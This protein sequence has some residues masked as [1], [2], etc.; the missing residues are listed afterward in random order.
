MTAPNR[1]R[2]DPLWLLLVPVATYIL[3]YAWLAAYHRRAQ[4]LGTIVHESGRYTLL[5]T[6]LYASHFLGHVP[7]QVVAALLL[8]GSFACLGGTAVVE[9]R[10]I[11][12]SAATALLLLAGAAL[13]GIV[14][15]GAD[16]TLAFIGQQKQQPDL[17]V[18]GGAW[19][20]HLPSTLLLFALTPVYVAVV[21]R[22]LGRPVRWSRR[23]LAW[24]G[25]AA[26]AVAVVTWWANSDPAG[27][28]VVALTDPRYAAHGLR[29]LV[30]FALLWFPL[31][32]AVLLRREPA[33]PREEAP[34]GRLPAALLVLAVLLAGATL[35]QTVWVLGHG[36]GEL[37]QKP[38]FAR[39][40]TLGIPYL[41]ASHTFEHV[42][43]TLLFTALCVLMA[44]G[45][46]R[47]R[48]PRAATPC[49]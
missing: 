21:R 24:L 32:L 34:P 13:L 29:E 3:S 4:L 40:G 33:A 43:D 41:L 25:A 22:L 5:E 37:A 8:V 11:R 18:E 23:G 49:R 45:A 19:N 7:V 38:E 2:L 1:A 6:V 17:Y 47:R 12:L 44:G 35:A 26:A 10:A 9:R 28:V 30:T 14:H 31:P 39:S 16:D 42:L 20:L 27:A 48:A 46:A 15:F 36:V